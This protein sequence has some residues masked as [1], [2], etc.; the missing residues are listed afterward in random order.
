VA[1]AE[2]TLE[3]VLRRWPDHPGANHLYIHAVESSRT[4]ERAIPSAQRLMGI[5]PG[6]GHMVHMPGH[7]W[8][9]LG[10]W[11]MAAEVNERAAEVDRQYFATTGVTE[12]SY[13][14]YYA[15]NL[16]FIAYARWMQ[17]RRAD[18][19]KAAD[20]LAVA[21][22]P[23][24]AA[25]PEMADAFLP[26][27]KFG[28]LRFGEWDAILKVPQPKPV[29][30][31]SIAFWHFSRAMAFQAKGDAAGASRERTA[32]EAA[33]K[34]LPADAPWGQ[35][36]AGPILSLAEELLAARVDGDAVGHLRRAVEI[37]DGLVYDEPPAWY[38]PVRE[39]LGAALVRA[40]QAAEAETVFREGVRR[41]PRNGRMLFGL[42]EALRAQG[43]NE[44]AEWVRKEYE[45]AWAKADV[46]LTLA[47]M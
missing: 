40:G 32:F 13:P 45:A 18:G 6:E 35:N 44:Q 10:D 30:K 8:L 26:V 20:D 39:S 23:M 41:S 36:Q 17:G 33:R 22:A 31:V 2:R 24:A 47:G 37:Q 38:Y 34:E 15:H 42:M 46:K 11:E 7:I 12:G 16:H 27:T 4:P 28:L 9:L 21:L 25:M 14:M 3:E 43:K 5:T 1:E 29:Q 19:L